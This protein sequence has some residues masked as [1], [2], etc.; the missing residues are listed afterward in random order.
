MFDWQTLLGGLS[1]AASDVAARNNLNAQQRDLQRGYGAVA[2]DQGKANAMIGD[3]VAKLR[4]STPVTYAKP[5][6]QQYGAAAQAAPVAASQPANIGSS[7]YKAGKAAAA[8]SVRGYGGRSATALAV[9]DA[10][11]RQRTAEG[12]A[13]AQTGSELQTVGRTAGLDSFLAQ[14][15]AQRQRVNPWT[16]LLAGIGTRIANNY[17]AAPDESLQEIDVNTI[18][19][20]L[21]YP[22]TSPTMRP[23]PTLGG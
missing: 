9:L 16:S 18:P 5:L 2:G 15:A 17:R 19:K 8:K 23:F 1:G 3:L 4:G 12:E 22:S 10:A 6:A 14:L 7:R 21:P 11:T 20:R 13:A